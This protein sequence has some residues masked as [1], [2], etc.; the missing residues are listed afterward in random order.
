[1]AFRF[2][3]SNFSFTSNFFFTSNLFFTSNFFWH[4]TFCLLSTFFLL[5]YFFNFQFFLLPTY[6][7]T[8]NLT[9]IIFNYTNQQGSSSSHH[10][11]R[12]S[13]SPGGSK[14]TH[15]KFL[16]FY[17]AVDTKSLLFT[18]TRIICPLIHTWPFPTPA[19]LY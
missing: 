6:F 3:T 15:I 16:K 1:M 17:F 12:R 4:L 5:S 14:D 13:Q 2:F 7:Y 8:S 19:L 18:Y 9:F 10:N 11:Q